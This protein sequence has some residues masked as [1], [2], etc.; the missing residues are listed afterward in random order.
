MNA[1]PR[2]SDRLVSAVD[3]RRDVADG[4]RRANALRQLGRTGDAVKLYR[5][6][7]ELRPD[8]ADGGK[9]ANGGKGASHRQVN[10]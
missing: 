1:V 3:Q 7:I 5:K 9:G 6:A 2:Q 4:C 10:G 8:D